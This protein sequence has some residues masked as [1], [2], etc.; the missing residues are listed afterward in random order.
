MKTINL[1]SP[2][3]KERELIYRL[4]EYIAQNEVQVAT[5]LNK[6]EEIKHS[7]VLLQDQLSSK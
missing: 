3:K 7:K 4:N 6:N 2:S 5:I 1:S